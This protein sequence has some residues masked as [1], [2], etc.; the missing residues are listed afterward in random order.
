MSRKKNQFQSVKEELEK[1]KYENISSIG[2]IYGKFIGGNMLYSLITP[3]N[4]NQDSNIYKKEIKKSNLKS[5][6]NILDDII[7]NEK[8]F[9]NENFF[10]NEETKKISNE[11]QDSIKKYKERSL[12][13]T[14]FSSIQ[15]I[16]KNKKFYPNKRILN[17]L[18][19]MKKKTPPMCYYEPKYESI[20][21]HI[22][23]YKL[24]PIKKKNKIENSN[25]KIKQL[26]RKRLLKTKSNNLD[27]SNFIHAM[28]FDKYSSR[29]DIMT[30]KPLGDGYNKIKIHK[31]I[32][33]PNF[34][35]MI[36]RE[37]NVIKRRIDAIRNYSPNYS[38]IYCDKILLPEI[39]ED[40]KKKKNLLRKS[41]VNY[42]ISSEYQVITKLN[43][44]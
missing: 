29:P 33:V 3:K 34:K 12:I 18:N 27:K 8:N 35:K 39:N 37:K 19:K 9:Q 17:Y 32:S 11:L 38:S 7:Q 4:N 40:L 5:T 25:I 13:P 26:F 24:Q 43:D 10:T 6:E 44:N 28:S 36:S 2:K 42:N 14:L 15:G 30:N 22:P 21:K 23:Q 41:L 20:D 1:I 16:K 31:N